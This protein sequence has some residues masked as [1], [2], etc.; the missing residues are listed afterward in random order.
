MELSQPADRSDDF[1]I[2]KKETKRAESE[3][4]GVSSLLRKPWE[5]IIRERVKS[6]TRIISKVTNYRYC[7]FKR[8]KFFHEKMNC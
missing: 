8:I 1:D 7:S 3:V 4:G 6:K 5:D 2:K